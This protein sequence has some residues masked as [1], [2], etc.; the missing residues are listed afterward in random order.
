[1]EVLT[2]P[3]LLLG[4]AMI[5][6]L[7]IERLVEIV[8]SVLYHLEAKADASKRWTERAERVRNRLEVRLD[9]CKA[10]DQQG[11]DLIMAL[12]SRYLSESAPS[13]GG[14]I[15]VSADKLRTMT[16]KVWLKSLSVVMGISAAFLFNIDILVLVDLAMQEPAGQ[17]VY[18][19]GFFGTLLAGFSMG[20]GAGPIHKMISALEEARELRRKARG[21]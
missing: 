5:L 20:L 7:I 12:A 18:A 19:P 8:K 9:Q 16:L 1:M 14:L 4:L 11:F 2:K 10:G 15:A 13:Q 17:E 21:L 3:V 6:A